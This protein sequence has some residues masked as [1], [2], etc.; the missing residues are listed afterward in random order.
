[1]TRPLHRLA[2]RAGILDGYTNLDGRWVDTAD[3]TRERLLAALGHDASSDEAAAR[4]LDEW[5]AR[6][7]AE[8]V[9]PWRV[10]RRDAPDAHALALHL[11]PDERGALAWSTTVRAAAGAGDGRA[12]EWAA[13][14]EGSTHPA[15]AATVA[16]EVAV[17]PAPGEYEVEVAVM[18]GGRARQARQRWTV[19]PDRCWAPADA[20]VPAWG[21]VANLYTLRSERNR[22]IGD[23]GD[24][25]TL[26]GR[27]AAMGADFVGVNPLHAI[28]ARGDG[29]SPYDPISRIFRTPLY[30]RLEE[31]PEFARCAAARELVDGEA[32]RETAA[33]L[34]AAAAVDYD[35][36]SALLHPVLRRLHETFAR[37]ERDR[38]TPRDRAYQAYRTEMGRALDDFAAFQA[39]DAHDARTHGGHRW[40]R[41]WPHGLADAHSEASDALRDELAEEIDYHRWLQFELDR[42]LGVAQGLA[43]AGGMR[44]GLYQDLA[45][46]SS[47]GGSDVWA[48]DA[49]FVRGVSI[50]APP[51]ALAPQGQDWGLPPLDPVRLQRDGFAY[52]RQLLRGAFRHAGALRIDHVLGLVRQFWIPHGCDGT[53]GAYVRFPAE[54]LLGILAVESHRARARV[55]GEDLG[56]VP[57]EV[58]PLLERWGVLR[59]QVVYFEREEDGRF[60]PAAEYRADTLTTVNTHDL[61]PLAGYWRGREIA[62]RERAGVIDAAQAARDC[63]ERA[64]A[65]ARLVERLAADGCLDEGDA[66]ALR[67]AARRAPFEETPTMA[68]QAEALR[69]A[70]APALD[71]SGLGETVPVALVAGVHRFLR[72]TPARLLG[73]SLDDLAG[74]TEPVNLP[75]VPVSRYPS[76]TRRMRVPLETLLD[77][78]RTHAALGGEPATA[79]DEQ[80]AREA[81]G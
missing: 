53:E 45:I 38:G 70:D 4:A 69:A 14:R 31:I 23:M 79:P 6:E 46:G 28:W 11:L 40:F 13:R 30:L 32:H 33:R 61:A 71:R 76:W 42:Q 16:V 74:E 34:R 3:P 60:R 64:D 80:G 68:A 57:P 47:G 9:A 75:G 25:A 41:E 29:V 17:P 50:G 21:L 44:V 37:E 7:Q 78:A 35:A 26:V 8:L 5:A 2:A 67:D 22:G 58:P 19:P 66:A 55:V 39:F 59:S 20:A 65:C 77:D 52:W 62:L 63:E 43:R 1:M 48:N 10:A 24:L 15:G 27:A 81:V 56:T 49:L 72:R 73:L 18:A 54:E 36:V 51:D 12:S